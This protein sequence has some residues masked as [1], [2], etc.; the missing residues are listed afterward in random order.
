MVLRSEKWPR[1]RRI[2]LRES[3]EGEEQTAMRRSLPRLIVVL[4][5]MIALQ[6]IFAE[7]SYA[8]IVF[9]DESFNNKAGEAVTISI[10]NNDVTEGTWKP[11]TVRIIDP[12]DLSTPLTEYVESGQGVWTANASGTVTFTPCLAAGVPDARCTA[13]IDDDPF[14]IDYVVQDETGFSNPAQVMITFAEGPLAVTVAYF[15]SQQL[16]DG[17]VEFRWATVT[18]VGTAGFNLFVHGET[19]LSQVND[20]FG[21]IQCCGLGR[22]PI[23][24]V[25]G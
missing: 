12:N 23:L 6:V 13:A 14:Q 15:S 21:G 9:D 19:G 7:A 16:G 3:I 2:F 17:E 8:Q 18:E 25:C 5:V 10:L 22:T 11:A 24:F 4:F 20:E 1:R